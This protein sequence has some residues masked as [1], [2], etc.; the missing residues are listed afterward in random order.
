MSDLAPNERGRPVWSVFKAAL[1]AQGFRPSRRLGQNFLLDENMVRAIVRDSGISAADRVLEIGSGCGFLTL[2]LLRAGAALVAV[3]IDPRLAEITRTLLAGEGELLLIETD[4]LASKHALAPQV[5]A[6]LP[7]SG[8]WHMVANLPYSVSG[9]V[10]ACAAELLNPPQSMTV[11]V[12]RE[13]AQRIAA[14]PA[15]D[16]WGP[17][18]IRLQLDYEPEITREV[19]PGLF[20]PR[21]QVASSVVR[22]VRRR[23][24]WP[25]AE[26]EALSRLV[27][28]LFQHRRQTLGRVLKDL[29]GTRAAADAWLGA[30]GF[31]GTERAEDLAL[32]DLARISSCDP[33]SR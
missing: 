1:E 6:A 23:E 7:A 33:R 2:H 26:R 15:T 28:D 22:L 25:R 8:P 3:E 12:Q 29:L 24:T 4:V 16:A 20:W 31:S 14:R 11:L 13:V 10:L 27:D 5:I 30:A 18:S 9:P 21:P 32:S 19:A 17:L